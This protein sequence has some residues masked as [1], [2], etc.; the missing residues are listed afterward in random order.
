MSHPMTAT[1]AGNQPAV[2][3]AIL[4]DIGAGK[5][6]SQLV[7]SV[8]AVLAAAPNSKSVGMSAAARNIRSRRLLPPHKVRAHSAGM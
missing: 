3:E 4:T 6:A 1:Y 7:G 8:R 2:F 5:T